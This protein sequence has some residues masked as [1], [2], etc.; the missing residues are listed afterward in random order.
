[1][2]LSQAKIKSLR[3]TAKDQIIRDSKSLYLHVRAGEIGAKVIRG[4][5]LLRTTR[6]GKTRK[7]TI[8]HLN[9]M[10]VEAARRE[11][12]RLTGGGT[13]LAMTVGEAVE[14]YRRLVT[15]KLKSGR[16]SEGYLTH[17]TVRM[18]QRKIA[19]VMRGDLVCLIKEYAKDGGART[20]DRYLSQLRGVFNL[21][22]ESGVIDQSPLLGVS[23]RITGYVATPRERV[24][25][26]DEIR[27]LFTWHGPKASLLRFLL[28]TGLRLNE[29]R[30]GHREGDRWIVPAEISKNKK[31]HW[32]Y[33]THLAAEQLKDDLSVG[34][35]EAAAWVKR[36]QTTDTPYTPH[37]CR[38][39]AATLM[40]TNCDPFTVERVLNH[41]L[42]GVMAVYNRAE[43][44]QPRIDAAIALEATVIS[45]ITKD[46]K[47]KETL[48][49]VP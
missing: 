40:A 5:W 24:L 33:I 45:I 31:S 36:Q 9:T 7:A 6:D 3:L 23:K 2:A 41:T 28:L 49:V 25:A 27:E 35:S 26:D 43:Y 38:R 39:S 19:S 8:G 32:V 21:A 14:E 48:N 22:V 42:A 30:K 34:T 44:E 1:M 47:T 10:S 37:D 18:G 16:Q 20:A 4:A 46:Q 15:D 13:S 29:A 17:L 12:D 11:R